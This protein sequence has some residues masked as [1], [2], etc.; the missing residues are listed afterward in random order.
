MPA[1]QGWLNRKKTN[2]YDTLSIKLK[3]T[4][5]LVKQMRKRQFYSFVNKKDSNNY[6]KGSSTAS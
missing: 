4:V 2:W 5:E 6:N 1:I 3:Q